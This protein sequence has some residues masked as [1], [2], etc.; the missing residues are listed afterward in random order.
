[1]TLHEKVQNLKIRAENLGNLQSRVIEVSQLDTRLKELSEKSV[2]LS[3]AST[4]AVFFR[5]AGL[6]M[7]TAPTSVARVHV[8]LNKVR[9]RF[10]VT[11]TA[12]T[13]TQRDDWYRL[14]SEMETAVKE[15]RSRNEKSWRGYLDSLFTGE[16]PNQMQAR[17]AQTDY[18][19]KVF[20]HYNKLFEEFQNLKRQLP[21]DM[22]EFEKAK[23]VS[24]QLKSIAK[25][26]DFNVPHAVK[27]F[28]KAVS[29][30][31]A[32]LDM[33]TEEVHSWLV[34]NGQVDW[35]RVVARP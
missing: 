25:E 19:N 10:A 32:S 2:G 14:L 30:G 17:M 8:Q 13:L 18:N 24:E 3:D 16:S 26:F 9:T 4:K 7:D 28:L 15:I 20:F 12:T 21:N 34:S 5:S 27:V 22:V 33:V 31:G 29:Q 6:I 35:Y 1:M 11:R 23:K